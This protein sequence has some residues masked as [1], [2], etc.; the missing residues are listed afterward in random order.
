MISRRQLFWIPLAVAVVLL[1]LA[2][3]LAIAAPPQQDQLVPALPSDI[4][5][6][7]PTLFII[8]D[9]TVH[10]P[11]PGEEGWGDAIKSMF[12]RTRIN[13]VNRA[14]GSS[15]SRTFRTEGHWKS[16]LAAAKPGDFVLMQFGTYDSGSLDNPNARGSIPGVGEETKTIAKTAAATESIQTFGWYMEQYITDAKAKGMTPIIC[17]YI[18]R[19]PRPSNGNPAT[20]PSLPL[21]LTS[22]TL[23]AKETAEKEQVDFIN[24]NSIVWQ[25]YAA[26][27]PAELKHK[28]F[29]EADYTHTSPAG[30]ELNARSAIEGIRQLKD[31]ALNLYLLPNPSA[32]VA[33]P[34]P[35]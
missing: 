14:T 11:A 21:A 2:A 15:S 25:H 30:A 22:Y 1:V 32:G 31:S 8:G 13:V 20:M 18:P 9:S 3:S 17:S 23:W 26:F 10:D 35:A 6:K 16:V 28:F 4:D 33:Q 29:T 5:P 7:L 24:L 27:T 12:D 34:N 19:C